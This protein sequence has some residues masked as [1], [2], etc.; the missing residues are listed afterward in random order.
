MASRSH[1]LPSGSCPVWVSV[2]APGL[3]DGNTVSWSPDRSRIAFVAQLD[4]SRPCGA[5]P[6]AGTKIDAGVAG[7]AGAGVAGGSGAG[8]A[9]IPNAAAFVGDATTGTL[10]EID[11]GDS[12]AIEWISD[13]RL[14][15]DKGG[16]ITVFDLDG[17]AP[18]PLANA[19]GLLSPRRRPVCTP[20]LPEDP[21]PQDPDPADGSGL[22]TADGSPDAV[23][24]P[25][26]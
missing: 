22:E 20:A 26:L 7:V 5:A 25:P 4:E 17:A 15:I 21:P 14:M 11:R 16:G 18:E 3:I 19:D 1:A 10:T 24:E 8:Q 13:R 12:L 9:V 23:V 6:G 2:P